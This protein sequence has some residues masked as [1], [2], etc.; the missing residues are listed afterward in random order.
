MV[1][2][3]VVFSRPGDPGWGASRR[4]WGLPSAEDVAVLIALLCGA[5]PHTYAQYPVFELASPNPQLNGFFGYTSGIPD[6]SGDGL[7]DVVVGAYGEGSGHAYVFDGSSGDL[8]RILRSPRPVDDGGFGSVEGIPDVNGDGRGDIVVG[9][10]GENRAYVF[11]GAT[12]EVLHTLA[13]PP[14][15]LARYFG[16]AVS[17]VPD[18]NGDGRVD[19]IVGSLGELSASDPRGS[20]LA[21]VFDGATGELLH[22]LA[23]PNPEKDG[24]FGFSVS[25]V[26]DLNGDG[27]G[28]LTIGAGG[29]LEDDATGRNEGRAYVFDG[30]TGGLLYAL[31]SPAQGE[32]GSFGESVAGVEDLDGDR[33]GDVIVGAPGEGDA[34]GLVSL[35]RAYVFS[36]A[37]GQLL[38]TLASPNPKNW[39]EFGYVAGVPDISGDGR[40]EVAVGEPGRA[41]LFDGASGELL[42]WFLSPREMETGEMSYGFGLPAAVPDANG[43]GTADLIIGAFSEDAPSGTRWAGRAY[44]YYLQPETIASLVG[45]F[46][47]FVLG[48]KPVDGEAAAWETGYFDYAVAMDVDVRFVPREM[49]RLFFLSDEYATRTRTDAEFVSD[50]YWAFLDR[51]PRQAELDNWVGAGDG[52]TTEES[53]DR[54]VLVRSSLRPSQSPVSWNRAEVMTIFAESEEFAAR[55]VKMYPDNPGDPSRNFVTAMYIGLLDRLADKEGLEYAASLFDAAKGVGQS[56][57]AVE[58][59]EGKGVGQPPSAVESSEGKGVGQ[60]PSAV[61]FSRGNPGGGAVAALTDGATRIR[62]S[63]EACRTQ[64]KQTAREILASD[65]FQNLIDSAIPNPHSAIVARLYRAFLGRFPADHEKSYWTGELDASRTTT[66]A[67]IDLFAAAPEFSARLNQHFG[68]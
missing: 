47:W 32:L 23:S 4:R 40:G 8:L 27:L 6:V 44:V 13:K 59:S 50:C 11:D 3:C 37:T 63:I 20:G 10:Y 5:S 9:A 41:Y 25:G 28:D 2:R 19:I 62:N 51:D 29:E 56:P 34:P 52:T 1:C 49:G 61:E 55:I 39:G 21:C 35:G 7:G 24:H 30:S 67:M 57:S 33:R 53:G 58:S 68:G 14:S 38:H 22:I 48:R 18:V 46:Y 31:L 17:G 65:E 36:G 15:S 42:Q 60:S 66:D 12:G 64:A 16:D 54:H 26:S 45:S 43:D